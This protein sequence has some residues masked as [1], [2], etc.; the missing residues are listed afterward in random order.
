MILWDGSELA[1]VSSNTQT[2]AN[3]ALDW[4]ESQAA[5]CTATHPIAVYRVADGYAVSID[6][7]TST[8]ETVMLALQAGIRHG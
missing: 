4:L 3:A 8:G 1:S 6:G 2:T 5:Y 7:H